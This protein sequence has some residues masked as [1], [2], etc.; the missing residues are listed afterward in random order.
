MD[1]FP[2]MYKFHIKLEKLLDED[3]SR[4][5]GYASVQLLTGGRHDVFTASKVWVPLHVGNVPGTSLW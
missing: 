1:V 2:V 4:R 3:P 5:E